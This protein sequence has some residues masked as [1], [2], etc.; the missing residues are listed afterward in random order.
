[1]KWRRIFMRINEKN[2]Q[3]RML[4]LETS[5]FNQ[6]L[7]DWLDG[8]YHPP[9]LRLRFW[10]YLGLGWYGFQVND[11]PQL[12]IYRKYA[13]WYISTKR[14]YKSKCHLHFHVYVWLPWHL[15]PLLDF[16]PGKC[17]EIHGN[18]TEHREACPTPLTKVQVHHSQNSAYILLSSSIHLLDGSRAYEYEYMKHFL[19]AQ[20]R[21]TNDASMFLRRELI[22][23]HLSWILYLEILHPDTP[24]RIMSL[25][26]L[27]WP[28]QSGQSDMVHLPS[29]DLQE[30]P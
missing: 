15:F 18:N 29:R 12:K 5:G 28:T 1:M 2:L 16:V 21:P 14:L 30:N 23:I 11:T 8:D 7:G 9:I 6:L 26:W 3:G 27:G 20:P 25:P 4:Y 10:L 19:H 13:I 17:Y 24:G 22:P